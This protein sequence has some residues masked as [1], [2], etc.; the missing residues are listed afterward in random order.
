M[1]WQGFTATPEWR[2][3]ILFFPYIYIYIYNLAD[4]VSLAICFV[5]SFRQERFP[6]AVLILVPLNSLSTRLNHDAC[7]HP[8]RVRLTVTVSYYISIQITKELVGSANG[9]YCLYMEEGRKLLLLTGVRWM[10]SFSIVLS[11][12]GKDLAVA[13]CVIQA[14]IVPHPL[15]IRLSVYPS[16]CLCRIEDFAFVSLM[17]YFYLWV[18]LTPNP[19]YTCQVPAHYWRS[20]EVVWRCLFERL[21]QRRKKETNKICRWRP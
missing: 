4:C 21:E 9:T 5:C 3:E 19:P 13:C 1:Y 17:T 6:Q 20:K 12:D 7:I 16:V 15:V 10:E 8:R 11:D 18:W 2:Q 14:L